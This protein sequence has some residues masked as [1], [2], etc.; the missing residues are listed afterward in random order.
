MATKIESKCPDC[1]YE[2][3]ENKRSGKC[4]NCEGT[5][6]APDPMDSFTEAATFGLSKADNICKICSG[7]GQCQT[8]GGTGYVYSYENDSVSTS[9]TSSSSVGGIQALFIS[10]FGIEKGILYYRIGFLAIFGAVVYFLFTV[11][12]PLIVINIATI[13]LLLGLAKNGKNKFLFTLSILGMLFLIL[14]YNKGW[15]TIIL[16]SNAPTFKGAIPF[17]FYLNIAAGL[18]AAYFLIRDYLNEKTPPA[19]N[20]QEFSKRNLIVMGSLVLLGGLTIGGQ[21]YFDNSVSRE[22]PLIG[23]SVPNVLVKVQPTTN[24]DAEERNRTMQNAMAQSELQEDEAHP[25]SVGRTHAGEEEFIASELSSN[26]AAK[27]VNVKRAYFYDFVQG[28]FEKRN[29]ELFVIHGDKVTI[30]NSQNGYVNVK[31]LTKNGT[32]VTGWL[33]ETDLSATSL[34]KFPQGTERLLSPNDLSG[35]SKE[36]LKIMRNEIFAR[37]GYIF[38]TPEMKS[39][40][41]AQPWYHGQ[42]EDVTSMLSPI[43]KQNVE[44]IKKNE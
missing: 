38:K 23:Y 9:Q 36:D 43:E 24:T 14:D 20:E 29:P 26:T 8:C 11:A 35:L 22:I 30:I 13:S 33:L 32:I 27:T 25:G 12:I 2:F 4:R 37:H 6:E 40:F 28:N 7:T 18:V 1:F 16:P 42:Y 44:L 39:Y 21:R 5:G 19:E 3:M 31:F 15:L 10:I 17:F 41:E 34:G